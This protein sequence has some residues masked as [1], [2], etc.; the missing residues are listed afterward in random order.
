MCKFVTQTKG[1][2]VLLRRAGPVMQDLKEHKVSLSK[3]FVP[4]NVAKI[5][6]EPEFVKGMT[7]KG[8]SSKA[9]KLMDCPERSP[10]PLKSREGSRR[11][12][13]NEMR[14]E[15]Q[16]R[17]YNLSNRADSKRSAFF[18]G[19]EEFCFQP[20]R[21]R[22]SSQRTLSVEALSDDSTGNP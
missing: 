5:F 7:S 10:Y 12:Q 1:V 20:I 15:I 6:T 22:R 2:R 18:T 3:V 4:I 17:S 21:Q 8:E 9:G 13:G 14:R 11:R 16:A 19:G